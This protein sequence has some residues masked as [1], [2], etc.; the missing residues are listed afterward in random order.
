MDIVKK[1]GVPMF[2]AKNTAIWYTGATKIVMSQNRVYITVPINFEQK[3]ELYDRKIT[4]ISQFG[5]YSKS[6]FLPGFLSVSSGTLDEAF[7]KLEDV[8]KIE[9]SIIF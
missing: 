1:Y 3:G 2:F 4:E 6:M 5:I 7:D 8:K 9:N